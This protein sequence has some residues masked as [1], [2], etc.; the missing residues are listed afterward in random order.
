MKQ[1]LSN[2][3]NNYIITFIESIGVVNVEELN[4]LIDKYLNI[5][6]LSKFGKY[7][8]LKQLIMKN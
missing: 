4:N 8:Y 5:V 1:T 3:E 2:N 7:S 6:D